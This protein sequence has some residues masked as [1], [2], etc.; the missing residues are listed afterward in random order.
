V[1]VSGGISPAWI[2]GEIVIVYEYRDRMYQANSINF[3]PIEL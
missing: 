1:K 3:L 2:V